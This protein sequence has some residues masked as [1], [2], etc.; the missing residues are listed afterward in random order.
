MAQFGRPASDLANNGPWLPVPA[1]P[2]TLFDKLNEATPDDANYVTITSSSFSVVFTVGLSALIDPIFR[3]NHIVYIRLRCSNSTGISWNLKQGATSIYAPAGTIAVTDVFTTRSFV[4]LPANLAAI[5]DYTQLSLTIQAIPLGTP[6]IDV[7][8]M[9]LQIP[10]V[11]V[12]N[13]DI[14]LWPR[15]D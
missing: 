10:D 11:P 9:A 7:S 2:T 15:P 5:T 6:T 12:G 3:I 8:W 1:S 14:I 4:V 13:K